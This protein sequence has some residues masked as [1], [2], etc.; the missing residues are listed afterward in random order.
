MEIP[1]TV[2]IFAG[3]TRRLFAYMIDLITLNVSFGILYII[4]KL[5]HY[6]YSE[7]WIIFFIIYLF[8]FSISD[9]LLLKGQTA[10]KKLLSIQVTDLEGNYIQPT[11]AMARA[12]IP[13][14]LYFSYTLISLIYEPVSQYIHPLATITIF[15]LLYAFMFFGTTI[16][17]TFHP[18]HQGLHDIFAKSLVIVKGRFSK[19]QLTTRFNPSRLTAS[20]FI[21]VVL[22]VFCMVIALILKLL[23]FS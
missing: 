22:T 20:Y 10:G 13:S 21:T 5:I 15:V 14:L 23:F 11:T 1:G 7:M 6:N 2:K 4:F 16:F 9:S 12:I 19:E 18:F 3:V 8:Y 17:M